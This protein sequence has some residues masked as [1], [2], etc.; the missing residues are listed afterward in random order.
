V[1]ECKDRDEKRFCSV[2]ETCLVYHLRAT[3][4]RSVS[5]DVLSDVAALGSIRE[6]ASRSLLG[7]SV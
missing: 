2:F 1:S 4:E 6:R 5:I 3:I 7:W